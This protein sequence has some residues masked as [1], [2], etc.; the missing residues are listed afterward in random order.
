MEPAQV[1]LEILKPVLRC[2]LQLKPVQFRE[3]HC[4]ERWNESTSIFP[5]FSF[6]S[7]E[8]QVAWPSSM[9][10]CIYLSNDIGLLRKWSI[11]GGYT[12]LRA[13][14]FNS[15]A[16]LSMFLAA[17]PATALPA[18][19]SLYLAHTSRRDLGENK[20]CLLSLNGLETV[21]LVGDD[22]DMPKE[23]LAAQKDTLADLTID[24][25]PPC[26]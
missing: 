24:R 25:R 9:I 17:C 3:Y 22:F 20:A 6:S 19:H 16:C 21:H 8:S 11:A 10:M 12:R 23:W 2:S 18:L 14:G 1:H 15:V 26:S 4:W 13:L 5:T 7:G